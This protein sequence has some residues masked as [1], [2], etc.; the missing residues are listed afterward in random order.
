MNTKP[1]YSLTLTP[2]PGTWRAQPEQRLRDAL[3][4]LLRGYGLRCVSCRPAAP[5]EEVHRTTE[6]A[7]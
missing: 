2:Q 3:K 1:V 5:A 6:R 7:R 4:A